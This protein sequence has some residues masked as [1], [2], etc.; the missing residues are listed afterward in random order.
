MSDHS[1]EEP[2]PSAGVRSGV[3]IE[4]SSK[5]FPQ[6]KVLVY[7][8]TTQEQMQEASDLALGTYRALKRQLGR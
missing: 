2:D 6:I 5:G 1:L 8:G 4:E 7:E 3:K